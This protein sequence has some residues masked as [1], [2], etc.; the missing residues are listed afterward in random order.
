MD[1]QL[2][3]LDDRGRVHQHAHSTERSAARQVDARRLR[4]EAL[5]LLRTHPE[6]LTDDEGGRLMGGDRLTFGRRRNE[7][8]RAGLA[9]KTSKRR[10]TPSGK[11]AIVWIAAEH[12]N[13][14]EYGATS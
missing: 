9:A 10:P 12:F 6:G 14:F 2:T 8:V 1:Q 4:D 5:R 3:L 7:L 13:H 11:S